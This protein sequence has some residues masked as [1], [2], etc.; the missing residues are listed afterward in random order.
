[1][2]DDREHDNEEQQQQQQQQTKPAGP[3]PIAAGSTVALAELRT[4]QW[5]LSQIDEAVQAGVLKHVGGRS[6]YVTTRE[7]Y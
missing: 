2:Y 5:S 4:R 1:M 6:A 7:I 3:L